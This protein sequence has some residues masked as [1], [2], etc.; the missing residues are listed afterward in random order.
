MRTDIHARSTSGPAAGRG[1]AGRCVSVDGGGDA[2]IAGDEDRLGERASGR[3]ERRDG[4]VTEACRSDDLDGHGRLVVGAAGELASGLLRRAFGWDRIR[5]HLLL[6]WSG[7]I[8]SADVGRGHD[9][10]SDEPDEREAGDPARTKPRT[11]A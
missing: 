8:T 9:E 4:E 2:L 7:P 10:A 5:A 11:N 3:V 6:L 1:C